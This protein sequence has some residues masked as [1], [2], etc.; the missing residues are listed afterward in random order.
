[1]SINGRTDGRK[2]RQISGEIPAKFP[3]NLTDERTD[4]NSAEISAQIPPKFHQITDSTN[5]NRFANESM[6]TRKKIQISKL[7][8]KKWRWYNFNWNFDSN[9]NYNSNFNLIWNSNRVQLHNNLYCTNAGVQ[10]WDLM[11]WLKLS[12]NGMTN[13]QIHEQLQI[14]K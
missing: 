5:F 7:A 1:M 6:D 3:P 8:K 2:F 4:G 11:K 10:N 9:L 12:F 14:S 13:H